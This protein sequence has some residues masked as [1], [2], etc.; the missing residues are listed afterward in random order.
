MLTCALACNR[1][2]I[3]TFKIADDITVDTLANVSVTS[4]EAYNFDMDQIP[5]ETVNGTVMIKANGG[6]SIILPPDII[7]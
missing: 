4:I 2:T 7:E 1:C 3:L 5:F 6:G